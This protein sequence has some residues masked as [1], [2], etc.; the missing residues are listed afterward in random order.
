LQIISK[1]FTK[2]EIPASF[3][4]GKDAWQQYITRQIQASLDSFTNADFGT[5]VV[6][7]IVGTNGTVIGAQAI[8]MQGTHLAEVAVNAIKNGPKWIPAKQNGHDVAAYTL[9]PVTLKNPHSKQPSTNTE[10]DKKSTSVNTA[11]VPDMVFTKLEQTATFPGGESA[12]LKYISR[13]IT[14]NGNELTANRDNHGTCKVRFIVDENGKVSDVHATTMKG[15]KLAEVAVNAIKQGPDWIPGKQ[16]G[17]IVNSYLIQPVSFAL[18]DEMML[19]GA[20][21]K[22]TH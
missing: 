2:T 12:W 13:V 4:G 7:F 10:P 20:S 22:V 15:T 3:P 14:Q 19:K 1:V 8:T 16:N 5:C 6:K 17:H 18:N 11:K 9:Q 21:L